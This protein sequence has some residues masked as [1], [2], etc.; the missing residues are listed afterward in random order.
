LF[1]T[2]LGNGISADGMTVVGHTPSAG[3]Y[4]S[5][6]RNA[7][8]E[9][10]LCGFAGDL[11]YGSYS[12]AYGVSANGAFVVGHGWD[13]SWHNGGDRHFQDFRWTFCAIGWLGRD[14]NCSKKVVDSFRREEHDA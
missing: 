12:F 4:P 1:T 6:R 14:R 13:G 8:G 11:I 9:V 2:A 10:Q 5:F 7:P 3:G